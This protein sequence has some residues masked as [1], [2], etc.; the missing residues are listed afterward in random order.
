MENTTAFFMS[1]KS[2]NEN[3]KQLIDRAAQQW[4]DLLINQLIYQKKINNS[5]NSNHE[6]E[7][8]YEKPTF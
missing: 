7:N 6:Q 8:K 2:K 5:F 3:Q 1:M 4:V